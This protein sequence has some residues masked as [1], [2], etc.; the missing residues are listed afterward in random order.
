MKNSD[1]SKELN[2]ENEDFG[3]WLSLVVVM[4]HEFLRGDDSKWAPYF[5]VLPTQFDTL[6]FWTESEIEELQGSAVVEKIG[7]KTAER[8]FISKIF[9]VL[10]ER[11]HLFPIPNHLDGFSSEE[12][13]EYLLSLA[14]RMSSLIMAYAFDVEEDESDHDRSSP[15]DSFVT[16]DEEER[17][18][19]GMIP[20]ADMLNADADRNNVRLP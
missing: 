2:E 17:I 1:A 4:I 7:R 6:M 20:L 3:P 14:H 12:G 9:P 15:E 19:K 13:R 5:R 18:S 11:T 8:E 16:D 10:T